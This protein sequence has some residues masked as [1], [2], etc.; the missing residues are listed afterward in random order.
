[1][2]KKFFVVNV[3]LLAV[4]GFLLPSVVLASSVNF[5]GVADSEIRDGVYA[6]LYELEIDGVL[7]FGM[8]DDLNTHVADSWEGFIF[9]YEEIMAGA[10]VKFSGP[11]KYSQAGYLFSLLDELSFSEQADVNLAVWEIMAPESVTTMTSAAQSYYDNATSGLWDY[12]DYSR[13][14]M[15]LTPNPLDASQEYLIPYSAVP[16]PGSFILIGFGLL[17][18]VYTRKSRY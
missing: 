17:G 16:E 9:D 18:L 5:I 14:M 10:P 6:G 15:V 11:E 2:K 12:Y 7:T 13:I 3:L 8:C 1:M 4:F